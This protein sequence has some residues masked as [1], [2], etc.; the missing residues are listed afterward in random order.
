M[1]QFQVKMKSSSTA[2]NAIYDVSLV[3]NNEGVNNFKNNEIKY[4]LVKNN[5]YLLGS[6]TSGYLMSSISGFEEKSFNFSINLRNVI[7][8]NLF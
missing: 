7:I 8:Q 1:Y 2:I 3:S 6:P 5:I 4:S